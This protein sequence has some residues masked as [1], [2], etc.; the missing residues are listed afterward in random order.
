MNEKIENDYTL[1]NAI[2]WHRCII[3]HFKDEKYDCIK[4]EYHIRGNQ[5]YI[6]NNIRSFKT[7]YT[8][9]MKH[10]KTSEELKL[11]FVVACIYNI[12]NIHKCLE[13]FPKL[14]ELYKKKLATYN[15]LEHFFREDISY[16]KTRYT[17]IRNSIKVKEGMSCGIISCYFK[18]EIKVETLLILQ[19]VCDIFKIINSREVDNILWKEEFHKIIKYGSF[20]HGFD[21]EYFKN[22]LS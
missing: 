2:I 13:I 10:F 17:T 21:K 15:N 19:E 9:L 14:H 7:P 22:I 4:R 20:I 5:R 16:L 1:N 12:N 8:K 18:N 11:F 6:E 3:K